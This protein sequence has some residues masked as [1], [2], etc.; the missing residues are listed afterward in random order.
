MSR[1]LWSYGR[2]D[3]QSAL[4]VGRDSAVDDAQVVVDDDVQTLIVRA[5]S[6][7]PE[8]PPLPLGTFE[9][10]IEPF[11][12]SCESSEPGGQAKLHPN[13]YV[14]YLGI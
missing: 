9:G 3:R 2:A 7:G 10:G 5:A 8:E 13:M 11:V 12:I 4:L 6:C 14:V 1:S